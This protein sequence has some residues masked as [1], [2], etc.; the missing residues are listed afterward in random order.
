[1]MHAEQGPSHAQRAAGDAGR[2]ELAAEIRDFYAERGDR[3]ALLAAFREAAVIVPMAG[4]RSLWNGS[5]RGTRWLYAFTS[6]GE[7]QRFVHAKAAQDDADLAAQH[8]RISFVTVLG[9]RLLDDVLPDLV[10]EV[11]EPAGVVVDVAG[12]YPMLLPP[13]SGVVPDAIAVDI[14]AQ[15]AMA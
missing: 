11:R 3:D 9:F 4:P 13:T 15:G 7:L 6:Q 8:G 12:A 1:M 5:V 10:R 2:A 14:V